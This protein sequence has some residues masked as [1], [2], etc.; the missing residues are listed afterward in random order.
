VLLGPLALR[1]QSTQQAIEARLKGHPLYLR[2]QW[3]QDKLQFDLSGTTSSRAVSA[4]FTLCGMDVKRIVLAGDHLEVDGDRVG[5]EFDRDNP[6]RVSLHKKIAIDVTGSLGADYGPALDKIFADGLTA[7]V[8]AMPFYWQKYAQ[9][10]L[11]G[12]PLA[13]LASVPD[14]PA[15]R[16]APQLLK[17]L[18]PN[19]HYPQLLQG[20]QVGMTDAARD[21]RYR[22]SALIHIL[23]K[24]DGTAGEPY[25]TRPVGLGLDEQALYAVAQYRFRP[26][27]DKSGNAIA[28]D[29][30]I[31]VNF[32]P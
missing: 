13:S 12:P 11:L 9:A 32:E 4:P 7:L 8:P 25:I 22:A 30:T 10:H 29:V 1:A 14:P 6:K 2:G 15:P 17:L 16:P 5:V 24:E 31:E 28:I 26:A 27:T 23:V 19:G 3:K 18:P 20:P 21:L